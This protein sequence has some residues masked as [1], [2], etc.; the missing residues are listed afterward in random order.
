MPAARK[1]SKTPIREGK[2]KGKANPLQ[3]RRYSHG[4][5]PMRNKLVKEKALLR[6]KSPGQESA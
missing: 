3:D 6:S 2:I 4:P 5:I 1:R